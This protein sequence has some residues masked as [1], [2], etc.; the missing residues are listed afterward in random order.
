MCEIGFCVNGCIW[1]FEICLIGVDGENVGVV[2]FVCVMDF[3]VEVEFD[4][5]EI[6]L[7]V[8]LFVCK[9]MDYGKFKYEI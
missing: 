9:I 4:L 7:N 8:M 1:V 6:L 3:V 5:V 2:I